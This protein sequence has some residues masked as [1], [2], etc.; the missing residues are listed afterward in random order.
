[1]LAQVNMVTNHKPDTC[2]HVIV[3]SYRCHQLETPN[4]YFLIREDQHCFLQL[5]HLEIHNLKCTK[6]ER[7]HNKPRLRVDYNETIMKKLKIFFSSTKITSALGSK[8][9]TDLKHWAKRL[10]QRLPILMKWGTIITQVK[11]SLQR[12]QMGASGNQRKLLL[13]RRWES[14]RRT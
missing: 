3:L 12:R 2:M 8:F 11:L 9:K 1:M 4:F 14:W 6:L 13:Q 7:Q 5:Q 10:F